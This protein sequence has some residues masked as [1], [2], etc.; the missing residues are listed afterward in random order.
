MA[1]AFR[2]SF[3][4]Q[5]GGGH[6]ER[7]LT[8]SS[9]FS[10][11][12][13]II[14][15]GVLTHGARERIRSTSATWIEIETET[16][17]Y[18]DCILYLHDHRFRHVTTFVFDV[19]NRATYEKLDALIDS[20]KKLKEC[21]R[22]II[23]IDGLGSDSILSRVDDLHVDF[24]ITP[25]VGATVCSGDFKH[26]AGP[27]YYILSEAY[28]S[29]I[30]KERA[31]RGNA[32]RILVTAGMSDPEGI[33]ELSLKALLAITDIHELQVRVVI[34]A[35][36]SKELK[37]RLHNLKISSNLEI[38]LK[39]YPNGLRDL[40]QWADLAI[41]ASGLTKY[42]L[43][44]TGT[45][46]ITISHDEISEDANEA[47]KDQGSVIHLG[48]KGEIAVSDLAS[49]VRRVMTDR[50]LRAQLSHRGRA[51]VDGA[52][53]ERIVSKVFGCSHG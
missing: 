3:G 46:A 22:R 7:A 8:L 40:M 11:S 52:G 49:E 42:E 38:E 26:F 33:S 34:G 36:F 35:G 18:S 29:S 39:Q 21:G 5:S 2:V 19:S 37:E 27:E 17:Y 16:A 44:A 4:S 12:P 9:A 50:A 48:I 30:R 47:F 24:V 45:P 1:V 15:G 28:R 13:L 20:F 25:Y 14:V 6:L 10:K 43:A 23:V 51:L 53:I 41:S 31:I 32:S